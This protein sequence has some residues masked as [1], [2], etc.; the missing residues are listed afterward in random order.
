[1]ISN[2]KSSRT[3]GFILVSNCSIAFLVNLSNFMVTKCTSPLTLQVLGNAKVREPIFIQKI[4]LI[5]VKIY[6]C[7][8]CRSCSSVNIAFS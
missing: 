8:G 4:F 5:K 2:C 3:F 7:K 1:M 6:F